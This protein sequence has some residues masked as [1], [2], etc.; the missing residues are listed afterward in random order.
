ML[1]YFPGQKC[2]YLVS[3]IYIFMIPFKYKVYFNSYVHIYVYIQGVSDK[4]STLIFP[5]TAHFREK[6][7]KQKLFGF[8]GEI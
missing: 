1:M 4:K 5:K 7:L 2:K 3:N 6:C 8:E